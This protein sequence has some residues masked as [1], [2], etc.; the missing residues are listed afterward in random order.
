MRAPPG[1]NLAKRSVTLAGHR[2]S[3]SIEEPF[4]VA[5]KKMAAEDRISINALVARIDADR[6]EVR[7]ACNLSS[8]V[9]LY[10]L[11][12]LSPPSERD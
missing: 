9:R 6:I 4:W 7:P 10:I 12:R 8:A 5:L 11:G 2:T 1:R 3:L